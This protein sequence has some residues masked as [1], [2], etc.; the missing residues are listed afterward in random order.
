MK[1]VIAGQ[2]S[3]RKTEMHHHKLTPY[4]VSKK[5]WDTKEGNHDMCI[6]CGVVCQKVP[7]GLKQLLALV[8]QS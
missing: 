7:V 5:K 6:V 2:Q 1:T 4:I 8:K 3:Y